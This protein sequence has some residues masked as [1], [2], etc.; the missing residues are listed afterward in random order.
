MKSRIASRIIEPLEPRL[1]MA[2]ISVLNNNDSGAG[3][4]RDAI[5]T[6]AAGDFISLNSV[7]GTITLLS[8]LNVTKDLTI[9]GPGRDRLTLDGNQQ[10]RV[11][12]I[13]A[14]VTA[15]ISLLTI[16]R[17]G[18]GSNTFLDG[19]GIYSSGNL[20]LNH[21]AL[22]NNVSLR[23]YG[24]LGG[25]IYAGGGLTATD[26]EFLDNV[27][28]ASGGA[29][30]F[31]GGTLALKRCTFARNSAGGFGGDYLGSA[32]AMRIG[33]TTTG[34][35]LDCTISG[36]TA[37]ASSPAGGS[38]Q[39]G[40][41]YVTLSSASR[42]DIVN[43]TITDNRAGTGAS[44]GRGGGIAYDY[45]PFDAPRLFLANSIVAGNFANTEFPDVYAP[46][47]L[48]SLGH[49]VIRV[50]NGW[51][52]GSDVPT[53]AADRFGTAASP[54]D[55]RL[56]QLA[57]NG[58]PML[59]HR[60]LVGSP[61]IDHGDRALS[62]ATD[63]NRTT[64]YGPAIDSGAVEHAAAAFTTVAPGNFYIAAHESF[65]YTVAAVDHT[66]ASAALS[67]SI[68]PW[69][70][71][72]I[73]HGDG[74][75]TLSGMNDGTPGNFHVVLDASDGFTFA[76]QS[77]M[78]Q[79]AHENVAPMFTSTPILSATADL[80]YSY[81]LTAA[82]AWG[83]RLAF[84]ASSLPSWLTL[85]DQGDGTATLFGMPRNANA[86][87]N[88]VTIYV[89]DGDLTTPQT[90]TIN[91]ASM[92]HYPTQP[93]L[94]F[95]IPVLPAFQ[96]YSKTLIA[97]DED[98][99]A[100]TLTVIAKPTWMTFTNNGDG[101]FTVSGT[102]TNAAAGENRFNIRVSD[103]KKYLDRTYFLNVNYINRAP[104]LVVTP[105][106]VV[107]ALFDTLYSSTFRAIDSDGDALSITATGLPNWLTLVDHGNGTAT[108][109]GMPVDSLASSHAMTL[110]VSDGEHVTEQPF[111]LS[112]PMEPFR[113]DE[114]G[115]VI[116][117]G[118]VGRDAI[119]VWVR[120]NQVRAVLN[121]VIRNF[122]LSE[123]TALSVYGLDEDD[124]ISVNMRW[125]PAYVLG[126]GGNDRIVGGDERDFFIGGGGHDRLNGGGGDDRLSGL[127]NND[128]LEGGSGH[129]HL[130]GGDGHDV[131]VGN[132]GNDRLYGEAGNDILYGKDKTYDILHG[133]AGDDS[134]TYDLN[135]L[136]HDALATPA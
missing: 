78:V 38:A 9:S 89:T 69:W 127:G 76:H 25:A 81:K 31:T 75:G 101:T 73:D 57:Y 113:M 60:P 2:A 132:S 26:C 14:G 120:E 106:T 4:L 28:G 97:F 91:V 107:T 51:Y 83:D 29:L 130:T 34:T 44:T 99:D 10:T 136:L 71:T 68:L 62:T 42:L 98:G 103:G 85:Q 104:Q 72:L 118:T 18:G 63:Q 6:A 35:I 109:F 121:S 61:A 46:R 100:L 84:D 77:F 49:N 94:L 33:G 41:M 119:Q 115:T 19:A 1:L 24:G 59:T 17:G 126:G 124:V 88:A 67:A 131:L 40:A 86:G 47:P 11:M 70:L 133:G 125:I 128:Y 48:G 105:P 15:Q 111:V 13:S 95:P 80:G 20:V 134:G 96:P 58:G 36:N 43:T 123:V 8:P 12:I 92:N 116:V 93:A 65:S 7:S 108:L 112:V 56:A 117:T 22:R 87:A 50:I 74:T 37:K 102:P 23:G 5:A 45:S 129:D 82:D 32:G 110:R 54:L 66:G 27:A 52:N 21:V 79:V 30:Y 114:K 16:A 53:V 55:A 39:G 64:R 122:P 3:S 135:D 90:F